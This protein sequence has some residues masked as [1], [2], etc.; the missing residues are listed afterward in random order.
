LKANKCQ[1]KKFKKSHMKN[2]F[3]F[4]V[5]SVFSMVN[6]TAQTPTESSWTVP[7]MKKYKVVI[8][9]T[10][11]DTAVHR[12]MVKQMFNALT[13][14][15]NTKIEVV[16]HNNGITFLQTA[17]T[18][19][20]DKIKELKAKGVMFAACENTLKERKIEKSEIVPEAF[21][22]PA[23]IIEVVDKQSKKWAYLKAGF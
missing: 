9:C 19:Q 21:F 2:L 3:L 14:A 22:V 16:C 20:G 12:A 23:G 5:I 10:N 4:F 15:P 6:I 1:S 7:N 17:K 8:Q 18:L 13:A 11:G